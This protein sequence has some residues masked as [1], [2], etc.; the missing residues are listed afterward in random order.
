M[1]SKHFILYLNKKDMHQHVS[2][3]NPY[4]LNNEIDKKTTEKRIY[5]SQLLY[6]RAKSQNLIPEN[7][8]SLKKI[9]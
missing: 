8:I 2:E 1:L 9:P 4:Y 7:N 6:P 3:T 5:K